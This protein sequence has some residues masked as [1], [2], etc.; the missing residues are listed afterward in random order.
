MK[1]KKFFVKLLISVLIIVTLFNFMSAINFEPNYSYAEESGESRTGSLIGKF[2]SNPGEAL[3]DVVKMIILAPFRAAR[4]LNYTLASSSGTTS[5][6]TPGEITPFDIFFNRFPLLN[7]NIF[8][9]DDMTTD[10]IAYVIRTNAALWYYAI[11]TIAISVI[12]VMLIWNLIR[13]LSKSTSAEQKTVA[14][15]SIIDWVLSFALVMF[16]HIIVIIVLNFNDMILDGIANATPMSN[17]SSFLDALENSVFSTNLVLGIASLIVYALLNWQTLKY[18]LV[19]INRL[20][21]VVLL[22]MISP[23]VPITYS[24]DR[25]RG[26]KGAI[27]N[28]WFRELFYNVFVQVLHALVY[29][30]LV[31]VAMAALNNAHSIVGVE[32]LGTAIVAITAMLFVKYA[33]RMVKSI[34]GFNNSQ[35]INNNVI[36]EAFTSIGNAA[37]TVTGAAMPGMA[38]LPGAAGVAF[39]QN[40]G[41]NGVPSAA[42]NLFG[43]AVAGAAGATSGG[44]GTSIREKI[45]NA[46]NNLTEGNA[47]GDNQERALTDGNDASLGTRGDTGAK[48]EAGSNGAD[49]A[50]GEN[51]GDGMG[52][53]VAIAGAGVSTDKLK[54]AVRSVTESNSQTRTEETNKSSKNVNKEENKTTNNQTST[55]EG[56][57]IE[58]EDSSADGGD[59]GNIPV[60]VAAG[61]DPELMQKFKSEMKAILDDD[62]TTIDA[63]FKEVQDKWDSFDGKI[64]KELE[65]KVTDIIQANWNDD[66][67]LQDYYNSLEDGTMEKDYAKTLL[68]LRAIMN[69]SDESDLSKEEKIKALIDSYNA[70]GLEIPEEVANMRDSSEL[71]N[72]VAVEGGQRAQETQ[73]TEVNQSAQGNEMSET[74][75]V[76]VQDNGK[77]INIGDIAEKRLNKAREQIQADLNLDIGEDLTSDIDTQ[78]MTHLAANVNRLSHKLNIKNPTIEDVRNSLS[79]KDREIYDRYMKNGGK[80]I[81]YDSLNE[82]VKDAVTFAKGQDFLKEVKRTA[83]LLNFEASE[84]GNPTVSGANSRVTGVFEDGT[85]INTTISDAGVARMVGAMGEQRARINSRRGSGRGNVIDLNNVTGRNENRKIG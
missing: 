80:D 79:G 84:R 51:G 46:Y 38:G 12:A 20:L 19:Y 73:S 1:T 10:S 7:A 81:P 75:D 59:K 18:I 4:S 27:L 29:T 30:S 37:R 25:M 40:I 9:T 53:A 85:T 50:N 55:V 39:G 70:Q 61:A 56:D 64:D 66:Q 78:I 65:D 41:T 26:G 23:V 60:G 76:D 44:L 36:S 52:A 82:D 22:V 8:T 67:K 58:G 13:A 5:G 17:T 47:K 6:V 48:G 72:L 33:E 74:D 83:R 43:G 54:E 63:W 69:I 15:N 21:T 16:M 35:V 71:D 34:F 57:A 3:M 62:K 77:V 42:G 28:G 11:R 31:G 45:G 2:L 14:K 49:G 24:V 32:D 68:D